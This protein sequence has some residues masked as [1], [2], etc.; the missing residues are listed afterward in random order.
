[1]EWWLLGVKGEGNGGLVFNRDRVSVGEDEKFWRWMTV[2][3]TVPRP[4]ECTECPQTTYSKMVKMEIQV[5]Y[6]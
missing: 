1:M 2:V 6:I 5:M 3:V 4:Y